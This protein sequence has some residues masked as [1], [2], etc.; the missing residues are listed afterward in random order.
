MSSVTLTGPLVAQAPILIPAI[1]ATGSLFPMEKLAAHH[2]G[3]LHLAVSIFVFCGD[4]LLIQRRAF[5][6]YHCGGQWANTCCTHPHWGEQADAS[7]ARRLG[8]ELGLAVALRPCGQLD[9]EAQVAPDMRECER[10]QVYRGDITGP[11]PEVP[12]NLDEV[13]EIAWVKVDALKADARARPL[14]YAPWLRIYL[15]RWEELAL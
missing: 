1:D 7:A 4:E 11:K 3:V 2:Q 14:S 5:S 15:E 8:E 9:Y 6:K 10:V 13:C 12:F